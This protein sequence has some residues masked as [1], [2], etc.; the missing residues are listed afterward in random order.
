MSGGIVLK[1]LCP[2]AREVILQLKEPSLMGWV[3]MLA[4]GYGE[5]TI[6]GIFPK[7]KEKIQILRN[8]NESG[9]EDFVDGGRHIDEFTDVDRLVSFVGALETT[10]LFNAVG[11][12]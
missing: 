3:R 8:Y 5:D 7:R 4:V 2:S 1:D 10:E 12:D 9:A 11:Q 6:K